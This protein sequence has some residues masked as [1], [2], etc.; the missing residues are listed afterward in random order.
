MEKVDPYSWMVGIMNSKDERIIQKLKA[1][2]AD[3]PYPGERETALNVLKRYCL[4]HNI[5]EEDLDNS[6]QEQ[7]FSY[8]VPRG[9]N[10]EWAGLLRCISYHYFER[11]GKAHEAESRFKQYTYRDQGLRNLINIEIKC[12]PAEFIEIIAEYEVYAAA[13]KK[14]VKA[15]LK[16]KHEEF[17]RAFLDKND[18]LL[19]PDYFKLIGKLDVEET[20]HQFWESASYELALEEASIVSTHKQLSLK[21]K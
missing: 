10:Q 2:I 12:Y 17:L 18:L 4:A 13:F 21:E 15:F 7:I 19:P 9:K 3:T 8:D 6:I 11:K 1:I 14:Q 5:S 20:M 16:K